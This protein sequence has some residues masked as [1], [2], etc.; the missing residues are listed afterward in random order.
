MRQ[1]LGLPVRC[2]PRDVSQLLDAALQQPAGQSA[3]ERVR[4]AADQVQRRVSDGTVKHCAEKLRKAEGTSRPVSVSRPLAILHE[5][6]VAPTPHAIALPC[7]PLVNEQG[8]L[9]REAAIGTDPATQ[10]TTKCCA[11]RGVR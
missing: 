3:S 8:S 10:S 7:L 6:P 11:A 5:A 2:N 1:L 4:A 9:L